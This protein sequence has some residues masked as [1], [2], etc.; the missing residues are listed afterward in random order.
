MTQQ[1]NT[2]ETVTSH[3]RIA[4]LL[5]GGPVDR[6]PCH[7]FIGDHAARVLGIPVGEYHRSAEKMAAA[8]IAAWRTY[9]HDW[10]GV[11]PVLGI[12]EVLGS[13]V[14][15][16]DNAAPYFDVHALDHNADLE[17][18]HLPD[19]GDPRI[20]LYLDAV[21]IIK[22]E[23][24]HLVPVAL[25]V[26]SPFSTAANLRGTEQ[27]LRDIVIN[28][29]YAHQLLQF[30]LEATLRVIEAA[31]PLGITFGT[32]DPVASGSL[33]SPRHYREFAQPYEK[34]LIET[35]N[36]AGRYPAI[37]HI[38]G[39]TRKIWTAMADTGAGF[40]S[41]DDVVD[42]AAAKEAV[43][44]RV[45]IVGN[46]K[47]TESMYLGD[48]YAVRTDALECLRKAADSPKGFM[49][50]VGCGMPIPAPP[51]NVHALMDFARQTREYMK[52]VGT[53]NEP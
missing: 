32:S 3:E 18:L 28:P 37:L 1:L 53:D 44:D 36:D 38:C 50:A 39:N 16:S 46:V 25:N 48:P 24:G 14:V 42:L 4:A 31:R 6:V 27:L 21:R 5:A 41:L 40:L 47:P 2:G 23:I 26:R 12:A 19:P 10:V 9:G 52:G 43:G 49:L 13:T 17:R 7:P 8:Q 45:V 30:A 35:M 34:V 51:A 22:D 11:G 33:I 15:Y 20:A 29:S